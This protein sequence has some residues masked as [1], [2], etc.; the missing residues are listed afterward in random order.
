MHKA[1]FILLLSIAI[2]SF[3]YICENWDQTLL[4]R[5][6]FLPS[7]KRAA[8]NH[9]EGS[10]GGK[11]I[12]NDKANV[13]RQNY[14]SLQRNSYRSFPSTKLP[15]TVQNQEKK[16]SQF[17][18]TTN[19]RNGTFKIMTGDVK[20]RSFSGPLHYK[21]KYSSFTTPSTVLKKSILVFTRYPFFA[22]NQWPRMPETDLVREIDGAPCQS[23]SQH[24]YQKQCSLTYDKSKLYKADAVL[25]H[26]AMLPKISEL[27]QIRI[28]VPRQQI[29]VWNLREPPFHLTTDLRHY[30]GLFNWTCTYSPE[31]EIYDPI[32]T[33]TPVTEKMRNSRKFNKLK[34]ER[35]NKQQRKTNNEIIDI[36]NVTREF[37]E[38]K[39]R[40]FSSVRRTKMIFVAVNNCQVKARLHFIRKLKEHVQVDVYG[41]CGRL[42]GDTSLPSCPPSTLK[43]NHIMSRYRF[44][45]SMENSYCAHYVTEKYYRNGL[46][47]GLIPIVLGGADYTDRRIAIPGSFINVEDFPDLETLAA[48]LKQVARNGTLFNQYHWWRDEFTVQRKSKGCNLCEKIWE[49]DAGENN[50]KHSLT[51]Q[52]KEELNSTHANKK[53]RLE[54]KQGYDSLNSYFELSADKKHWKRVFGDTRNGSVSNILYDFWDMHQGNGGG[55]PVEYKNGTGSSLHRF[56]NINR[57]CKS[58]GT[59]LNKYF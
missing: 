53:D 9:K 49:L 22:S 21:H 3:Y 25:F 51:V 24:N 23:A 55:R 7:P 37:A 38:K 54:K 20:N 46:L 39:Q 47:S 10:N 6:S 52:D 15:K 43:C 58:W 41:R 28:S 12:I 26:E 42:V 56:W 57:S 44:Y 48:F 5:R 34:R 16:G 31:S 4:K 50:P 19:Q 40:L 29:W 17:F 27:Q 33:I 11:S 8:K 2:L 14:G 30:T 35:F 1:Y 32:Y 36:K 18:K 13:L 45:L 59:V